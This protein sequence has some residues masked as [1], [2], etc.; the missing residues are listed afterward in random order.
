MSK[1]FQKDKDALESKP[2]GGSAADDD[3]EGEVLAGLFSG[4]D[5]V[6]RCDVCQTE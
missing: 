4:L 1:D 3:D 6:K 2:T 5:I